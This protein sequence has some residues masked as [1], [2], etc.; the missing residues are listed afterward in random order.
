MPEVLSVPVYRDMPWVERQYS[1]GRINRAGNELISLD[2]HDPKREESLAVINNWRSC[3]GYTLQAIKMTLLRRARSVDSRA[4]IAQRLKRL[5]SIAL[6]LR[7]NPNMVLS[8][9]QDIGG[10]RSIL[11]DVSKMDRLIDIYEK[12]QEEYEDR[13]DRPTL[14]ERYDYV[15]DPKP[16]GYRSV[17][18]VYKYQA[19]HNDKQAFSGQRIE[20][21]IRSRLQH[22]WATAVETC[23]AF[24]GQALKAKIKTASSPEWLRFFALMGGAI[25][26]RER[27]PLVPETPSTKKERRKELRKI[28]K[29]EGIIK[30]IEGWQVVIQRIGTLRTQGAH[31]FLLALDAGRMTLQVESYRADQL[32]EA[33]ARYLAEE[34]RTEHDTQIQVVLVRV[35]SIDALRSAYP[36]FYV[37]TRSFIN[38]VRSEM[39]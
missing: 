14:I 33:H 16:D 5:P 37:D 18:F 27:R 30:H 15:K 19:R 22:A 29:N 21:Q 11:Q 24:T 13:G 10:C 31:T 38:V 8:Q 36:N 39:S 32:H 17:H 3:H 28:V 20:V 12:Y 26:A 25:A 4:L 6:K 35:D 7:Q 2:A 1:K 34:R 9:M 23:Q